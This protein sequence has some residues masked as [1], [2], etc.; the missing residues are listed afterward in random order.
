VRP[1]T[2]RQRR[3]ARYEYVLL[4]DWTQALVRARRMMQPLPP[5]PLW[6]EI[7]HEKGNDRAAREEFVRRW[8]ATEAAAVIRENL[9][10]RRCRRYHEKIARGASLGQFK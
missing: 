2:A 8:P 3:W 9:N 6:S 7:Y 10:R 4:I 1:L 5:E